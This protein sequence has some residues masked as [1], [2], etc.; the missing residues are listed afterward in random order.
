VLPSFRRAPC[1]FCRILCGL[2]YCSDILILILLRG[3]R[4]WF[5][6]RPFIPSFWRAN[7][8]VSGS[9][10]DLYVYLSPRED[11]PHPGD[12]LLYQVFVGVGDLQPID[13]H[14]DSH[15]IAVAIH[16]GH[17]TL[18]ITDVIFEALSELHLDHE[19]VIAVLFKLM[20]GSVLVIENVL[21]LIEASE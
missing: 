5:L 14:N 21:H 17:L 3:N 9:I 4:L 6:V 15:V 11:V 19:E 18:K 10:L 20:S 13:E 16:Q 2:V 8:F 7:G 1:R 12:F